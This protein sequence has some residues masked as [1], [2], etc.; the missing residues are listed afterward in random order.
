MTPH[1]Y[2][3]SP[4]VQRRLVS[5]FLRSLDS[6]T[7][8]VAA[9]PGSPYITNFEDEVN[10]TRSIHDVA[11]VLRWG[12][13]H[14]QLE[15]DSFGTN[16]GWYKAFFDAE[17]ANDYPPKAFSEKLA[18]NLP[19][20]HLDLLTSTLEVFSSLAAFSEANSTSGSKLSKI[21][22]LWLLTA[23]RIEDKDDWRTFYARWERTGRMLEHLFL[24]RIRYVAH[25]IHQL[26]YSFPT[27]RNESTDQ[28][29]PTRL[30]ELVHKY[31]F[32][33]GLSPPTTDL[34]L[35]PYPQFT[36]AIHPALFVRVQYEVTSQDRIPKTKINPSVL[37]ADAFSTKVEE[38]EFVELWAKITSAASKTGSELPLGNVLANETLRLLSLVADKSKEGV[39]SPE[40][41]VMSLVEPR[42]QP[43][44]AA[45]ASLVKPS[46]ESAP[47]TSA[48]LSPIGSDW[49]QFSASGFLD[50]D[51]S[52]PPLVSTL[53]DTDIEKT[54][55]HDIPLPISR[56]SSKRTGRKSL[57]LPRSVVIADSSGGSSPDATN[58]NSSK[59]RQ[60]LITASQLEV[61][62]LDEAFVDFWSDTLQDP[63]ASD[64]PVF[65]V[66]KFKPTLVPDLTFGAGD[67]K[68]R[69][70]LK[71]LILEQVYSVK[72]RPVPSSP[73]TVLPT[74]A[75]THTRPASPIAQ[76]PTGRRLFN[77]WSVSRTS[78]SS[79]TGSQ[80]TRKIPKTPK[81]GE[82]GELIEEDEGKKDTIHVKSPGSKK[83]KSLDLPGIK[84]S[85][86]K[87]SYEKRSTDIDTE[88]TS[89]STIVAASAAAAA[90]TAPLL[91]T[92]KQ[93]SDI[94]EAVTTPE[95]VAESSKRVLVSEST[96]DGPEQDIVPV[97]AELAHAEVEK[98]DVATILDA[99]PELDAQIVN[100]DAP[101]EPAIASIPETTIVADEPRTKEQILEG[102]IALVEDFPHHSQ[103]EDQSLLVSAGLF[104]KISTLLLEILIGV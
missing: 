59:S 70:T 6:A 36:T 40:L 57:E 98:A 75:E 46:T 88:P 3:A 84:R 97:E 39:K 72:P 66:C 61:I 1:W 30:L 34:Q 35:L 102:G 62:E 18:P 49:E 43:N 67:E 44:G 52:F 90:T 101:A 69:K 47:L 95:A 81:V 65:V 13:R 93:E 87:K 104:H 89:S 25:I 23:R 10:F 28:R 83:F 60:A 41:S 58:P 77:F 48:P 29:M 54:E 5:N 82:M 17:V 42:R 33:H 9:T 103:E 55:P 21:F 74:P 63:I 68:T 91:A 19:T 38:G 37:L 78:S 53:F 22:G 64:W 73:L 96:D 26:W 8:S 79:S 92:G 2:S 50:I 32:T 31:P 16:D 11:A 76:T 80:K 4:D 71:W 86:G 7:S 56:K 12:L 27:C 100:P 99:V 14:V 20:S 51:Q 24:A 45:S 85:T 15:S 94:I